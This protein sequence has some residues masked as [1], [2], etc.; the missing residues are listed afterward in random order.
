MNLIDTHCHIHS[1]DFT[2]DREQVLADAQTAGITKLICVGT[3]AADSQLAV[4]FAAKHDGVW[5]SVGLHPHD[6]K[7]ALTQKDQLTEL[8]TANKVVAIGECGLDYW[9][10][11]TPRDTQQDVLRFQIELAQK[12]HLPLIF[13]IRGSKTD[14]ND[15][16]KDFLSIFDS[17]SKAGAELKGVVHSFTAGQ[18]QLTGVL[19]RGLDVGLNGIMTFTKDDSQLAAAKAVPAGR[20]VLET[21]APYLTPSP[22]RGKVNE[23]QHL[24][25]TAEFLARLRGATTAQLAE[26]TTA[27]ARQ[28]FNI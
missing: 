22:K 5:A 19:S 9:Y 23:P 28:L 15:A 3:D 24:M 1:T 17:Y 20:M 8:A 12:Y 4:E 10:E 27:A 7:D 26:Q 25:L 16:F 14:P 13:H 21:D 6:A 18:E 11:H 2:L